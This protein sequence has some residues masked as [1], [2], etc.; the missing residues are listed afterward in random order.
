MILQF[1]L[2]LCACLDGCFGSI[3][4]K[5]IEGYRKAESVDEVS[6]PALILLESWNSDFEFEVFSFSKKHFFWNS[7]GISSW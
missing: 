4:E 7:F 3:V 2:V 6:I 5:A 1:R